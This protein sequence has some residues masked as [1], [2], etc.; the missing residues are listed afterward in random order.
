[1]LK[2]RD[3]DDVI[4][5]EGLI[6]R[7]L[8]YDHPDNAWFC[9]PL[10]ASCSIF[11]SSNPRAPRIA[12]DGGI[13][14]KFY[15]DEGWRFVMERFPAYRLRHEPLGAY[16]VGVREGQVKAIRRTDEGLLALLSEGDEDVLVRAA[17]ELLDE[18]KSAAGLRTG[19]FGLFGSLL[20]R[21]HHPLLSDIDLV[22]YGTRALRA[23]REALQ[24]LYGA[25][26]R[27]KNEFGPGWSC[28]KR[29]WPWRNITPGEF[30]WHQARKLIYG[31]FLSREARRWVK[32]ELEP[33]RAWS[34]VENRYDPEERIRKLGWAV[35]EAVVSDASGAPFMP[36]IY[37]LEEARF[38]R[39]PVR[40][41][42][43]PE[44]V[45]SYVEEFRL[46][47][48]EGEAV[49]AAGWLELVEGRRGERCQLVLTYGPRYHEQVVK[50]AR[51]AP[52][53]GLNN[54]LSP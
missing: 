51:R 45:L 42:P 15:G 4:T 9:E 50:V 26:E 24:G 21:F 52:T 18:L 22:V 19:D 27:F 34:E 47:A 43:E 2:L 46:Q 39:A 53:L 44:V 49:I 6:M 31:F 54:L 17:V 32:F 36:A 3:R 1:M 5:P 10:Y 35:V 8:G 30:L 7:V 25:G 41:P 38:L 20:H 28:R 12:R 48:E 37:R 29:S 11:S 23:A 14:L 16:L 40:N 33:V 13:W